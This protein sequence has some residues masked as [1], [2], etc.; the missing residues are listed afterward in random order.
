[1]QGAKKTTVHPFVDLT[2]AFDTVSRQSLYKVLDK[3]GYPPLLLQVII[4]FQDDMNPCIQFDGN[5]SESF[6]VTSGVNQGRVLVPTLFAI[7]FAVPFNMPLMG[8][9]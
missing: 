2:K 6:K 8:G 1:M 7:Y 3:I 9:G 4:S 5:T